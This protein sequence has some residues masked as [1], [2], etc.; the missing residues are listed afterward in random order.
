MSLNSNLKF[1]NLLGHDPCSSGPGRM[2]LLRAEHECRLAVHVDKAVLT[3]GRS[4][5][6]QL[7]EESCGRMRGNMQLQLLVGLCPYR[8]RHLFRSWKI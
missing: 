6:H 2:G 1:T 8:D 4:A 5:R 3:L 7:A